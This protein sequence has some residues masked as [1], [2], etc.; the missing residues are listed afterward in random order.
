MLLCSKAEATGSRE[1]SG[2]LL[3]R[4]KAPSQVSCK[5]HCVTTKPV[6][7]LSDA[8][9]RWVLGIAFISSDP[10][11]CCVEERNQRPSSRL[12]LCLE[13][14]CFLLS[15]MLSLLRQCLGTSVHLSA[16]ACAGACIF[17]VKGRHSLEEGTVPRAPCTPKGDRSL[18][19]HQLS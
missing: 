7:L 4:P 8:G 16:G 11:R 12:C 14:F 19:G 17:Q 3:S 15:F 18:E 6:G 9:R 1:L 10:S 5:M 2:C 13:V